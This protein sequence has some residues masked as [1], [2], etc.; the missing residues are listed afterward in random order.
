MKLIPWFSAL[1][2]GA[3]SF[4]NDNR[5]V[6]QRDPSVNPSAQV[7]E[8]TLTI[9]ELL[10]NTAVI[11]G[12]SYPIAFDNFGRCIFRANSYY[13]VEM[14]KKISGLDGDH[15]PM[16]NVTSILFSD[17]VVSN[18]NIGSPYREVCNFSGRQNFGTTKLRGMNV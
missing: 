2:A 6:C 14:S 5:L 13:S 18:Q 17:G 10:A 15:I 16:E 8:F 11:N 9:E 1:I 3:Y 4:S 7:C 12:R